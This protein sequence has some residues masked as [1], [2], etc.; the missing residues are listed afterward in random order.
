[1]KPF[2]TIGCPEVVPFDI[3]ETLVDNPEIQVSLIFIRPPPHNNHTK[4][5][6]FASQMLELL[7]VASESITQARKDFD[8]LSKLDVNTARVV[9]CEEAYRTV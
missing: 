4:L 9:L 3:F 2:L 1:M 6:V 7:E 8:Q 5:T